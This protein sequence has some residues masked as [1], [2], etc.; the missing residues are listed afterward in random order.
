MEDI[1]KSHK[2]I[3]E[4]DFKQLWAE[5]LFIFDANV[6]LDLYRLPE[7]ARTDL[8]NIMSDKKINTRVWLPFQVSLEFI[9]N[10]IEVVSEQ[11]SK[12]NEVKKI[13]ENTLTKIEATSTELQ[14]QIG[15]LQ[16][17]K[18]HSAINPDSFI[19]NEL[20]SASIGKLNE[21]L[22]Y[23]KKLDKE[24]PDVNDSDKIKRIISGIFK[25]KIGEP[26]TE[27]ELENLYKEGETRYKDEIPPGYKDNGKKGVYIFKGQKF[28]RKFGDLIVWN[29]IIKEANQKQLKY[30]ILVTGDGKEDW[31]QEKR[32]RKI[33]PRFELLDEIYFKANS[34]E[35]FHMYETSS[36]MQYAKKYLDI[37]VNEQSIEETKD[38]F[39]FNNYTNLSKDESYLVPVKRILGHA[40]KH[41]PNL[42]VRITN[43]L[44]GLPLLL[45]NYHELYRIF[46]QVLSLPYEYSKSKV[47]DVVAINNPSD[48][49]FI[50]SYRI[51]SLEIAQL[52]LNH[53]ELIQ[54]L[55]REYGAVKVQFNSENFK[56][57]LTFKKDFVL[58]QEIS[59]SVIEEVSD[60]E[61]FS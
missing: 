6:L 37:N 40:R 3:T 36:F 30:I 58:D 10:R 23:L 17:K 46:I 27:K 32:G 33:G 8:L 48:F 25:N 15:Q 4:E 60:D 9:W 29:E 47:V 11:K 16:L 53:I 28:E 20:F 43:S 51:D 2:E 52:S 34:V 56:I 1:F 21:F 7:S 39:N 42:R 41:F 57:N 18:R 45:I 31:W 5:G 59:N 38:L 55:M 49:Y 61:F 35:L 12:F 54:E 14:N 50:F 13:I 24:Q 44:S 19:N 26:L 22:E